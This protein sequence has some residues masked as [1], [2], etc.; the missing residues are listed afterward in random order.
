MTDAL[1]VKADLT[2]EAHHAAERAQHRG[3][4]GAVGAQEGAHPPFIETEPNPEQGLL[5]AVKG[6]EALDLEHHRRGSEPR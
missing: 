4:A 3:L 5:L 1:A 6:V 2:A